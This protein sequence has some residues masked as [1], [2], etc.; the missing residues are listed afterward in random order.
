MKTPLMLAVAVVAAPSGRTIGS[1]R[2][3]GVWARLT[4]V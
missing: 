3:M 4:N 2:F 1:R